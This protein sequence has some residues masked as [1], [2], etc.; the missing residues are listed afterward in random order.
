MGSEEKVEESEIEIPEKVDLELIN[1][2]IARKEKVNIKRIIQTLDLLTSGNTIPFVA[3]YRKEVTGGL[4]ETQLRNIKENYD[5]QVNLEERKLSVLKL[6]KDQGKLNEDLKENILEAEK[7]QRV[8]DLY[9]PYKKKYK[10]RGTKAREKGLGPL[11][12]MIREGV[13]KG[14]IE[15]LVEDFIDEEKGV[16][17]K[18]R[19]LSGAIDIIAEDTGLDPENRDFVRKVVFKRAKLNTEIDDEVRKG[20]KIL[21]DEN[22]KEIEPLTFET[23]FDFNSTAQ[24]IKHYQ[25]MALSRAE[26]LNVLDIEFDTPDE[27]LI[28]ELK[29]RIM[30]G[31]TPKNN[32]FYEYYDEGVEKGYK[33]YNIPSIKRELWRNLKEEAND[34]GIDVFA[35]NLKNLLMTPPLKNRAIIGIDPGYR[36]GCKVAVIDRYG[37]YLD[38]DVIYPAPPRKKIQEAK[39]KLISLIEKY[40]AYTFAIGNGTASQETE[41]LVSELINDYNSDHELEYEIVNESGAS[42]YSASELAKEE[43]PNLDLTVRGAISI[44]RRL[45]DPLSELIKIDPKSIGIG[46][47]QHDVNQYQLKEAL[48]TVIED[49]VNSVGVDLNTASSKLLEYVSG[50][51]PSLAKRIVSH[52]KELGG[53]KSRTQLMDVR[54]LGAKTFEQCAG[55][56]KIRNAKNPLDSTF[57]HPESY[58]LTEKILNHLDLT[59][60]DLIKGGIEDKLL[61][62][63][64]KSSAKKFGVTPD[65][66]RYLVEQLLKPNLDPRDE[67][68]P[69][70]LKKKIITLEDLKE[71]MVIT[72]IVRNVVDFGAFCDIGIKYNGLVHKS[73]ISNKFVKN[74]HNFLAV[75]ETKKMMII[76]ID[77]PRKRIQLSIKKV[78][79]KKK[80]N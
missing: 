16:K 78:P 8:E 49:C 76:G 44:A 5:S 57:V 48:G 60:E 22:G 31:H 2:K 67:L 46:L 1:K 7:L 28:H 64:P 75:G 47:Y 21:T 62:I 51:G 58:E 34:H 54:R 6:I 52:R 71:G 25:V 27:N 50:I 73:E 65:R 41:Q 23:Y 43:F 80:N 42:V 79:K 69:R 26:S 10:T 33:R 38:N 55:F 4:D 56:L 20:G 53:F 9:L 39:N 14:D 29:K 3:R 15:D 17:D 32:I 72:G 24:S 45:Q 74:P 19:A 37:D 35:K 59:K 70:E 61:S 40:D 66:I 63:K 68:P 77:K 30:K 13:K 18:E 36:T 12:E 11:A